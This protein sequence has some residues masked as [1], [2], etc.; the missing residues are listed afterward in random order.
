LGHTTWNCR[1]QANDI[2]REK[3]KDRQHIPSVA[4]IEDPPDVDSSEE[5][6]EEKGIYAF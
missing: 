6:I 5:S 4:M 3:V 2:L 1:Q